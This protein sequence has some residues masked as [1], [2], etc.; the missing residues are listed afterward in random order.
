MRTALEACHRG[1]GTSIIIG[2]AEAG[3]K[4][5]RAPSSS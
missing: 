5:R 4:S 1:W 3:K 2:V